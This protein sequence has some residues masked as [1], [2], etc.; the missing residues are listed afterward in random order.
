MKKKLLFSVFILFCCIRSFGQAQAFQPGDLIQCS[1][2]VFNLTLQTPVILGNQSPNEFTVNYFL[3]TTDAETGNNPISNPWQF[4][5]PESIVVFA[6][7][8]SNLDNTY[9]I[10]QFSVSWTSM[11]QLP[12]L[13]NVTAC[14]VYM[15]PP[16]QEPNAAY[17]FDAAGTSP[18]ILPYNVTTT[19]TIYVFAGS[20]I[21][22]SQASFTVTILSTPFPQVTNVTA[23]DSYTLTPLPF[24]EYYTGPNGT[25]TVIMPGTAITS[26]TTLY[27]YVGNGMCTGEQPFTIT[28]INGPVIA[29]QPPSYITI[30]PGSEV[31]LVVDTEGTNLVYNWQYNGASIGGATG[32]T[33]VATQPGVYSFS[34][35]NGIC[36]SYGN[37]IVVE[38]ETPQI[39]VN[40]PSGQFCPGQEYIVTVQE[41]GEGLTYS[42]SING[43]PVPEQSGPSYAGVASMIIGDTQLIT[44]TVSGTSC[45]VP[46]S[47]SIYITSGGPSVYLP[48][49]TACF[50]NGMAIFDLTTLFIG[51]N[52]NATVVFYNTEL[53]AQAQVNPVEESALNAYVITDPETFMWVRIE[54]GSGICPG[55]IVPLILIGEDCTDNVIS[56]V[57][58]LDSDNNGCT[59][60]DNSAAGIQVMNVHNNDISYAYTNSNG[61]YTFTNVADGYNYLS[62]SG[63]PTQFNVPVPLGHTYLMEGDTLVTDADFCL[64]AAQPVT[65]AV[66][67]L[68]Q[69]GNARPGFPASY[70]LYVY[71]NGTVNLSGNASFSYDTGKLE[72]V[73]ASPV[74]T[75]QISNT[76]NFYINDLAPSQYYSIYISFT[77]KVPPIVNLGDVLIF[78]ANMDTVNADATPA[79]NAALLNQ[80]VVNSYDPNEITVQQGAQI[81]EAQVPDY[82]NYTIHFQNTGNAEAVYVRLESDLDE[83]L[84]WTT[85]R[86]VASTH[87][88]TSERVGN[89]I[90][91]RFDNINLPGSMVDEPGSNGYVTYKV[92]PKATLALGDIIEAD[93]DIY[94]DFN[95]P[96]ATN[97]VTTELVAVLNTNHND[98]VNL[99]MYPNPAHG[100][101]NIRFNES[102]NGETTISVFD[103]QGKSVL[104]NT[105]T[106]QGVET[107]MDISKLQTG[108]YFMKIVSGNKTA[109]RK[110]IVK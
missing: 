29:M 102:V 110:L 10:T 90:V 66:T 28:I 94:F 8:T 77:V 109:V 71:N 1:N 46:V 41:E 59:E 16:L 67:Y 27:A 15:L 20:G 7:V 85:F 22:T 19:Q 91:F 49:M 87:N 89:H 100:N 2:E 63:M 101:V 48:P 104:A 57:I 17:Y 38:F 43:V 106:I 80:I 5:A 95:L 92:K 81:L 72:Y 12:P 39:S 55:S 34:V 68:W 98:F 69:M 53:D 4:V 84:D 18:I 3:S 82:L 70:M 86:P 45:G 61:E 44:C 97:T 11:P 60:N 35:S 47:A 74:E 79:D 58:R 62:L 40:S 31:N 107:N 99:E 56:G 103:L 21:C 13:A 25:G 96:I 30:C 108:M 42:W 26:S 50:E 37:E 51:E 83:K 73:G 93:A 64:T 75:S 88:Y 65:D 9:A 6:R 14:D 78:N 105:G 36:T 32:N 54:N 23:C 33:F 52:P 76:L 24:G